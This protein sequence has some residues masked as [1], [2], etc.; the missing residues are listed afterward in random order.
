MSQ[1][2]TKIK[3]RMTYSND[4]RHFDFLLDLS[5]V[6]DLDKLIRT[7]RWAAQVGVSVTLESVKVKTTIEAA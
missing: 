3:T 5:D 2:I 4:G 1:Q 6:E 7:A